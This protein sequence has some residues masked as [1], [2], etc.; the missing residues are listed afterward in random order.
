MYWIKSN[1][2]KLNEVKLEKEIEKKKNINEII[3]SILNELLSQYR[4]TVF[5]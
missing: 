5:R 2:T 1:Q 3:K 4:K